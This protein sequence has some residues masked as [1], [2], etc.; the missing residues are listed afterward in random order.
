MNSLP[1]KKI[2][3]KQAAKLLKVSEKTLRRWEGSGKIVA[4]RT[5][6]GHRRYSLLQIQNLKHRNKLSKVK[7]KLSYPSFAKRP[8]PTPL[9]YERIL[10]P[11]ETVSREESKIRF[12]LPRKNTLKKFFILSGFA[13]VVMSFVSSNVVGNITRFVASSKSI[14]TSNLLFNAEIAENTIPDIQKVLAERDALISTTFNVN[15]DTNFQE[16]V[17]V[18]GNLNLSGNTFSSTDDLVIA[19][20]GGG[21]SV[22]GGTPANIDLTGDDLFVSGDF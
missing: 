20:G 14:L 2:S 10:H 8:A 18:A 19:A 11:I 4:H 9:P 16:N 13:L 12:A 5:E 6:G 22:G 1:Q 3:I 21:S 17:D 15:V 7:P